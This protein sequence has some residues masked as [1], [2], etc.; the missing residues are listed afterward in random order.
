MGITRTENWWSGRLRNVVSPWAPWMRAAICNRRREALMQLATGRNLV[1]EILWKPGDH[2]AQGVP[3]AEVQPST[4]G[5]KDRLRNLDAFLV[6]AVRTPTQD[7]RY[8]CQQLTDVVVRALSPS[9]NDP[10]TPINGIDELTIGLSMPAHRIR[11]RSCGKISLE[12]LACMS[13]R[14]SMNCSPAPLAYGNLCR[15]RP[16]RHGPAATH[17]EHGRGRP[18]G[19]HKSCGTRLASNRTARARAS[20]SRSSYVVDHAGK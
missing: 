8:Q 15:K 14:N 17:V 1:I 19:L 2:L 18:A 5:L 20:F 9:I 13:R 6:G 3:V 7:I 16:L 4:I 11:T 12:S 10:S